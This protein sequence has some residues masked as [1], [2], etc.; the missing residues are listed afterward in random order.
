MA[1]PLLDPAA[2]R[3]VVRALQGAERETVGAVWGELRGDLSLLRTLTVLAEVQLGTMRGEPFRRL[4]PPSSLREKL[5]RRQLGPLVLLVRAVRKRAG[6]EVAMRVGRAVARHG[7]MAFLERMV[8]DHDASTLA[9]R[10]R[11]IA[12]DLLGRFFNAEGQVRV[13]GQTASI[14]VHACQFVRLLT[15]IGEADLAP[16]MCEA[17]L[18][19][20]D[21]KRRAIRLERS[22]TLAEGASCCDFVFRLQ[23]P[24]GT[25]EARHVPS[26]PSPG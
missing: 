24:S 8:P 2:R 16:L 22:R 23:P 12:E 26:P 3:Q 14:D 18:A 7:A 5:S 1:D 20:F 10:P 4:P 21:G 17:D 11:E 25:V 15:E 9:S 13:A 19:F 6:G